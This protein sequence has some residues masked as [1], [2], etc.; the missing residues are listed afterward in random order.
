MAPEGRSEGIQPEEVP[1]KTMIQV[2][3]GELDRMQ[4]VCTAAAKVWADGSG[5]DSLEE[6]LRD[7][8]GYRAGRKQ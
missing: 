7:L 5:T 8:G 6:P 1:D 3:R 4:I 2:E